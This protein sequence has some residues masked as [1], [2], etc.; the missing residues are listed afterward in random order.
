MLMGS[1]GTHRSHCGFWD[2]PEGNVKCMPLFLSAF[3]SGAGTPVCIGDASHL[4]LS[5]Q[6]YAP[7]HTPPLPREGL[8]LALCLN[9]PTSFSF[10][11][12]AVMPKKEQLFHL[13]TNP[14]C[15][16]VPSAWCLL[17]CLLCTALT[18]LLVSSSR[19]TRRTRL[20]D[21][22]SSL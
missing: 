16:S 5:L 13:M 4:M 21:A 12:S 6:P 3:G 8:A 17:C 9:T 15:T 1:R 19:G 22:P 18:L 20:R 10:P 11:T 7:P 2:G 14:R